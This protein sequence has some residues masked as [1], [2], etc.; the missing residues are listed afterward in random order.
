MHGA[1]HHLERA[2]RDLIDGVYSSHLSATVAAL[3]TA[4]VDRVFR[5]VASGAQTDRAQLR[6]AIAALQAGDVLMV[7]RGDRLARST[8]DLLNTLAAITA[9]KA[10]FAWRLADIARSYNVSGAA[11]YRREACSSGLVRSPTRQAILQAIDCACL[12][13][14]AQA[15]PTERYET[16]VLASGGPRVRPTPARFFPAARRAFRCGRPR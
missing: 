2:A 3:R 16:A 5:E 14:T 1:L 11:I 8:R 15:V 10:G 13:Y 4:G 9:S 12:A 6:K 7:T